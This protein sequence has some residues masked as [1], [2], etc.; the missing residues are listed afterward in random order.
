[1]GGGTHRR[2]F[3]RTRTGNRAVTDRIGPDADLGMADRIAVAL[4]PWHPA[5]Q[6]APGRV[7]SRN[8]N[9][10]RDYDRSSAGTVRAEVI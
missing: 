8:R 7:R 9:R 3:T 6:L 2:P 5:R 10:R 4:L 1:M